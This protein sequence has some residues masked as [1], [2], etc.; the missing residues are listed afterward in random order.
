M[1]TLLCPLVYIGMQ[2]CQTTMVLR[3]EC[4]C[5]RAS[6][7]QLEAQLSSTKSC[8]RTDLARWPSLFRWRTHRSPEYFVNFRRFKLPV[9]LDL[10]KRRFY[11]AL[12]RYQQTQKLLEELQELCI[13]VY[14]RHHARKLERWLVL[15]I[16]LFFLVLLLLQELCLCVIQLHHACNLETWSAYSH[17]GLRTLQMVYNF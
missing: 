16:Q 8:S 11:K 3:S 10:A 12:P 2:C 13:D 1:N 7:P 9:T 6:A 5:K 4:R 14:Q 15:Y 17:C